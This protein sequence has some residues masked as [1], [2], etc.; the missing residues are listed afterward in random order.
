M[1]YNDK[2]KELHH[3]FLKHWDSAVGAPRYD[4]EAWRQLDTDF[5]RYLQDNNLNMAK[6][7][8]RVA[9]QLAMNQGVATNRDAHIAWH[10]SNEYLMEYHS[11]NRQIIR[12]YILPNGHF[13]KAFVTKSGDYSV[14]MPLTP[15]GNI[16]LCREYRPGP[17]KI[18]LDMPGGAL[19]KGEDPK[20][21]MARELLEETG[22]VGEV[23][24]VN[25]TL[26]NPYSVQRRHT[27]VIKNGK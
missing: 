13:K 27:F 24:F 22:Y 11:W 5:H 25:T 6:H 8:I 19:N 26:V 20:V 21:G 7:Y 1:T 3:Q 9:E 23:E 18:M 12:E 14:G 15:E 16:V 2:Q 17:D 10:K 4:K